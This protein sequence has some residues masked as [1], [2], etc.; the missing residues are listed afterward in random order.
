MT[1]QN[2]KLDIF[3]NENQKEDRKKSFN[4]NINNDVDALKKRREERKQRNE[5]RKKNNDED[6]TAKCD[7][8][9]EKLIMKKK[10]NFK[11]NILPHQPILTEKIYVI[12]RKRPIFP[13]EVS[14]GEIDCL[15]A[16]NPSIYIHEPK[17]KIDGI[18]KYIEDHEFI[19]DNVFGDHEKTE[20]VFQYSIEPIISLLFE[21][22]IVT[23]FA[24]GQTGSGKTFTMKGIQKS[25]IKALFDYQNN[26]KYEIYLSFYEIYGEIVY[27]LLNERNKLQVLEDK[28]QI[29]QLLGLEEKLITSPDEMEDMIN[30]GNN[31]RTTHNTVTNETSSRSHAVCNIIIKDKQDESCGKLIL[32]DLAGSERAQETKSNIKERMNE[33]AKINKSLLALKECIR[34]LDSKKTGND[35]HVPFRNSKLS[36][37]LRDSFLPKNPDKAKI[38]MIACVSPCYSSAN[39]TWNTLYYTDSFKEKTKKRQKLGNQKE[40]SQVPMLNVNKNENF[41]NE[42][43]EFEEKDYFLKNENEF[44]DED[45]LIEDK[46]MDLDMAKDNLIVRPSKQVGKTSFKPRNKGN[47]NNVSNSQMRIINN[48]PEKSS[49][50]NNNLRDLKEKEGKD[51][52]E[53]KEGNNKGELLNK[54]KLVKENSS[55][56]NGK[57]YIYLHILTY[58][59]INYIYII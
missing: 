45:Y 49:L 8:E 12:V 28:N 38:I 31:E 47:S 55:G 2:I 1:T 59:L 21:K 26:K 14:L 34:A 20:Q 50:S 51:G 58:I 16:L 39:H 22:G 7:A 41:I 29:V 57:L 53:G 3:K 27:D 48:N 44:V 18:T 37:V 6:Q 56:V 24:Y 11:I 40:T 54:N 25:S 43:V 30:K 9:Y 10:I 36:L 19:F 17:I 5:D 42:D 46:V 33:G 13:K 32:V 52:K 4:I 35:N 23:C 15:S